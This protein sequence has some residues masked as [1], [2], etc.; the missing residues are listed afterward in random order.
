LRTDQA[1]L[2]GYRPHPFYDR[3]R[4]QT[5]L[6]MRDG[7]VCGRVA[8]ILNHDHIASQN[9]SIG[10]FGFFEAVDDPET[11]RALMDSVRGWFAD[12]DIHR[13]RG[14][15]NPGFNYVFGL[16]TDGFDSSPSFMMPY[17]PPYFARLLEGCGYEKAQ[18]FFAY[19][20]HRDMLP[21]IRAK[22]QPLCRQI[23]DRLKVRVVSLERGNFQQDVDD[24][25]RIYNLSMVK[26][27]GFAPMSAAEIKKTA[28]SLR[29]L[30]V[31]SLAQVAEIEGERVGLVFAMLDYNPRIKRSDGRLFPFGFLRLL[32][33]RKAI[34]S[35]R[36]VAA[37]VLP[38]Y[39]GLGLGL[40]LSDALIQAALDWGIDEAEFSWVAES[41]SL[42]RLSL[43]R[44][45]TRRI[46]T[47]RVYEGGEGG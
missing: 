10:F 22:L 37:S 12:Q 39:Q 47:Y 7:C 27:W 33:N 34:K 21:E 20:G 45:G 3:N 26:H 31:P 1:E 19:W 17:N 14:P 8:A 6:A 38:K 25:L 41:N 15:M 16:L 46:K 13:V 32:L 2:V 43:E 42:S 29:H 23:S 28:K 9:E 24:F 18:D 36:V 30:I 35:I 11:A 4:V 5:F 44:M 40:V